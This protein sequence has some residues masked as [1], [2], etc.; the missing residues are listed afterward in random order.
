MAAANGM[1]EAE[2]VKKKAMVRLAVAAAITATALAG[3]WWLDQDSA[4]HD[5]KPPAPSASAPIVPAPVPVAEAPVSE[6]IPE[7]SPAEPMESG[8]AAAKPAER[9]DL[10]REPPPPPRVSNEPRG[11]VRPPASASAPP[12]PPP[13]AAFPA[14]PADSRPA[15]PTPVAG[16]GY[17]VQL[18]VFS[19][20]DNA[21]DLLQRL[22]RQGIRA[23]ME[24]RVQVGPFLDQHEAEKARAELA[25]MGYSPLVTTAAA[26]K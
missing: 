19:N 22:Q 11:I 23:H 1:P 10:P 5:R 8:S 14:S 9:P 20:P 4:T 6:P 17:V 24:T 7:E 26:R 15:L 13:T 2:D 3:L 12:A 16:G 21:R 25:R 18:G